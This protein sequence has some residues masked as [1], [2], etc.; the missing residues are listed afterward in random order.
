V[1][2][3][4]GRRVTERQVRRTQSRPALRA[5]DR[6]L[7]APRRATFINNPQVRL[8][9]P[10]PTDLLVKLEAPKDFS[11]NLIAYV[12]RGGAAV[13]HVPAWCLGHSPRADAPA[14][15]LSVFASGGGLTLTKAA[16]TGPYRQGFVYFTLSAEQI[17]KAEGAET[18]RQARV[19]CG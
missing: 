11:V 3:S 15:R 4:H 16:D 1:D 8:T 13:P 17:A 9:L 7:G 5:R 2:A 12:A 10:S 6:R 14:R 18:C 19:R